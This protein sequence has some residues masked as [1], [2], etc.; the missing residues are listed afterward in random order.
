MAQGIGIIPARYGS[1]RFPGKPL[2]MVGG[3]TMIERVYRQAETAG[4]DRV[5]V[6]TDDERIARVVRDFGGTAA[7]TSPHTGTGTER[8]REVLKQLDIRSGR[9]I[10][11]QGDE[12]FI[13]PEQIKQVLALLENTEVGIA[14][15]VSPALSANEV[16]DP[17]RVKVVLD[18]SGRALY[19]S[20]LPIPYH[21]DSASLGAYGAYY[22]HLGIYG[23]Q[24]QTLLALEKL[25][26]GKLEQAENL[27]QLRWLENGYPIYTAVTQSRAEAIDTPEDLEAIQK[28]Y[29]L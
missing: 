24:A 2:A 13:A 28:K 21:R 17:N 22:I 15:L 12:P 1:T 20:R 18:T 27:E 7:M 10:N 25:A 11:I 26:P 29:F 8:C 16:K 14:T 5:I 23:F 4:L 9:V 6:A 19:F 3:L